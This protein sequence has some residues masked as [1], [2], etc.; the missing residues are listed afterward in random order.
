MRDRQA[1][2]DEPNSQKIILKKSEKRV[3]YEEAVAAMKNEVD[4]VR[5]REMPEKL[6]FL[7]HPRLYTAG[8]SA[9]ARDL[10]NP[11]NLP[12]YHA[13]RGGQWTYHGPGQRIV[14]VMLDLQHAH[15]PTPPH[16]IYVPSS[17]V[18]NTG[19]SLL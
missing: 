15:G 12:V 16:A 19:L 7:E 11:N 13:G 3:A 14:Y 6:W 17:Q 8:T 18:L 1:I 9:K 2:A 10:L 5:R 4:A